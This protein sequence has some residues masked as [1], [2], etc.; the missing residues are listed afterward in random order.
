M[1]IWQGKWIIDLLPG[2]C[3]V[4]PES[5]HPHR[6]DLHRTRSASC[7]CNATGWRGGTLRWTARRR[8]SRQSGC[9]LGGPLI[10]LY[11]KLSY[12]GFEVFVRE[13]LDRKAN[14]TRAL[15]LQG[16]DSFFPWLG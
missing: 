11:H 16:C 1:I 13:L 15:R 3:F 14:L 2:F 12:Q 5:E 7:V 4:V 6:Y 8:R 9:P 10:W